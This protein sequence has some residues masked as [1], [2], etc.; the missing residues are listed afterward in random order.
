MAELKNK[1]VTVESLKA[2]HDYDEAT[3]MK[4]SGGVFTDN[5]TLER[6][7]YP[8]F[9]MKD[10]GNNTQAKLE[11]DGK[12]FFMESRNVADD[13]SNSRRLLVSG[14]SSVDF[15]DALRFVDTVD[16]TKEWH[17]V[18][19]SHNKVSGDYWGNGESK[20]VETDG[21]G[22]LL[23]IS[24]DTGMALVSNRGA[25]CLNRL[26]AEISGLKSYECRFEGNNIIMSTASD[27]C[28]ANGV[29]YWYTVI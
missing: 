15:K 16:G 13:D 21:I 23:F 22:A 3:F 19:G 8:Q 18:Y 6:S 25:I 29:Q 7:E 11:L 1:V 24:S 9:Y 20:T 27:F 12:S 28:N 4:K 14:D 10:V 26:T 5:V 2:K 17:T